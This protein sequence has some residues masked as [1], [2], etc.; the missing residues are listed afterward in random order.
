MKLI[1]ASIWFQLC[2]FAAVLG[3][4][5]W[6]W[7]TLAATTATL[8]YCWKVNATS[9]KCIVVISVVGFILDT[10]NQQLSILVFPT[11]WLPIWL[12]CLWFLFPWYAYQLKSVLYRFPKIHVSVFGALG[13]TASYFAG[14]ELHA[15]EF[16]F[17]TG[18]T[19]AI[20]FLEWFVFML[21]ILKVYGNEKLENKLETE[22][23]Q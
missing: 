23:K 16:G 13:G 20:L 15:V 2:W 8:V 22:T 4:H 1:I 10:I 18:I 11:L 7:L 9:L 21:F 3:T 5:Q 6:Q 14:H 17:S 12:L 19:L